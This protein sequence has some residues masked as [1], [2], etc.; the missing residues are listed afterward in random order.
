MVITS[1]HSVNQSIVQQLTREGNIL[2]RVVKA[3]PSGDIAMIRWMFLRTLCRYSEKIF[4]FVGGSYFFKHSALHAAIISSKSCQRGTDSE[5]KMVNQGDT[6]VFP[7]S[8]Y[9]LLVDACD[10]T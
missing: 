3:L 10:V 1:G 7:P 8:S 6:Q 5:T 9:L 2:S 4:I